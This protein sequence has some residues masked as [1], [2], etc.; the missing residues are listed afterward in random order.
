MAIFT[1]KLFGGDEEEEDTAQEPCMGPIIFQG[2]T[3][4]LTQLQRG[5]K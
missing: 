4:S 1:R 5:T 3:N 2:S